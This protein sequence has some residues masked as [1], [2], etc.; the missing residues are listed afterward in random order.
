[1]A[2]KAGDEPNTP[3][4]RVPMLP[5]DNTKVD[6]LNQSIVFS[7]H[8]KRKPGADQIWRLKVPAGTVVQITAFK[9]LQEDLNNHCYSMMVEMCLNNDTA[10]MQVRNLFISDPGC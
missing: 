4:G 5:S 9:K 6:W 7:A 1:M 10:M 2:L 3:H 8:M